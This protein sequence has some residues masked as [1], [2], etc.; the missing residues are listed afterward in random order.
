MALVVS[1]MLNKN[2]SVGNSGISEI[3]V[4]GTPRQSDAEIE[5]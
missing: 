2:R 1:G 5:G 3:T 4:E